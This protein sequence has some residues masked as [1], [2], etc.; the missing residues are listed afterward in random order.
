[1]LLGTWTPL[2]SAVRLRVLGALLGLAVVLAPP[3]VALAELRPL[4]RVMLENLS[5]VDQIGQGI[6]VEDHA[7]VERAARRLGRR[8]ERIKRIDIEVFG[9]DAARDAQFDAYLTVQSRATAAIA[10]AAKQQ[11]VRAALQGMRQLI[12]S[13]CMGCHRDFRE[14]AQ[15]L[16]PPVLLMTTF[17]NAWRE[18][19][20]GLAMNDFSLVERQAREIQT[21]ERALNQGPVIDEAFGPHDPQVREVFRSYLRH[22][23]LQATEIERAATEEDGARVAHAVQEMW[24]GG[25]ISCHERFR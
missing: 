6:A 3:R 22:V 10:D 14:P 2:G 18:I 25:C 17:L 24:E 23:S 16:R 11:D 7:L 4:V 5:D 9:L 15:L 12:Q 20:R 19:I 8:A 13:G 1:M 21:A